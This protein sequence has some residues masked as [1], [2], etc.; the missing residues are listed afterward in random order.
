MFPIPGNSDHKLDAMERWQIE[1]TT[2]TMHAFAM[3]D[4]GMQGDSPVFI[5]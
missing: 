5:V 4:L 3:Q 2:C 1:Y